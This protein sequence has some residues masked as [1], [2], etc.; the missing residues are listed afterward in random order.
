VFRRVVGA[1]KAVDGV[2]FEVLPGETLGLV[3]ESG[4]GKSTTALEIM[5]LVTPQRGSLQVTGK[6]VGAL[7][8]AERLAMRQD[9]QIVFQ[10]PMAAVDPRMPVGEII[11]EPLT[12]HGVSRAERDRRVLEMLDLVGLAPEMTDRYPHEFSGGQRQRIG[13]ARSLITNPKVLV[14]DEPVSAL[15]VSVQAGVV[16]LL[17]DLRDRLGLSYL[18][19]AHDLAIVREIA[20]TIAVMYLGRIVEYGPVREVYESP[21]H[22]YTR[23]LMSAVPVPDP[24]VERERRRILLTG[25]LP[26]PTE[27][28]PGCNFASR[29][30]LFR[31]LDENRQAQ[32]LGDDPAPV[33]HGGSRVACHHV[34]EI[35]RLDD[36]D[37]SALSPVPGD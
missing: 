25:D 15:D 1:V 30:P 37:I 17:E 16:N 14:L 3:G 18:F 31:M 6:D 36:V 12:V 22:P 34:D 33:R 27:E 29:C 26:S 13:I 21:R 2:D 20:D 7:S 5:E 28:I 4:S 23:A 24:V 8:K 19:V 32:C 10:D 9:V 35:G 11:A